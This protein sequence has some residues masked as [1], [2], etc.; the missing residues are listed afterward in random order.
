MFQMMYCLTLFGEKKTLILTA[1]VM[2]CL[3]NVALAKGFQ[4]L[5]PKTS[6]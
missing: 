3:G 1:D 2:R 4:V 6:V 5:F